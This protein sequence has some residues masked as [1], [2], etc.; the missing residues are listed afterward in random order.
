MQVQQP[1]ILILPNLNIEVL[2]NLVFVPLLEFLP[3]VCL[4][5]TLLQAIL[6][7]VVDGI[8]IK[9]MLGLGPG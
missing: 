7:R 5:R 4:L 9:V 3:Q 1:P 2:P 8:E 6:F